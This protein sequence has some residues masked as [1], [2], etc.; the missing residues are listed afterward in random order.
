[1]GITGKAVTTFCVLVVDSRWKRNGQYALLAFAA[2]QMTYAVCVLVVYLR[3]F[4][5]LPLWFKRAANS[6]EK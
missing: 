5:R 4:G 1:M 2:G 3:Y 6:D